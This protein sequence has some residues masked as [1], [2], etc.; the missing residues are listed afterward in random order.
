MHW[1]GVQGM[2]RRI[3]TYAEGLNWDFWNMFVTL[4]SFIIGIAFIVFIIN[5]YLS[6]ATG[7]QAPDDPW[8]GA[9]LE[10]A[11]SSPPAVYNFATVP[12][13]TSNIPLWVEK[14]PDVYGPGA[15]G[16]MPD[17]DEVMHDHEPAHAPSEHHDEHEDH[18]HMPNPSYWPL[19]TAIGIALGFGGFVLRN[20]AGW[21]ITGVGVF[22][23][24][25]GVWSWVLEPAFGERDYA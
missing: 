2:P 1:L 19:V 8:D 13:V 15:H 17:D 11:T 23:L 5:A 22:L 25:L 6:F 7:E 4:G 10:W 20:E 3:Y 12:T 18:I 21:A 14:Y 9:T 16:H 24:V